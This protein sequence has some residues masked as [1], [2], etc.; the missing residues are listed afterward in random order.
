[1]LT[2]TAEAGKNTFWMNFTNTSRNNLIL[3]LTSGQGCMSVE[4]Y[5]QSTNLFI[6]ANSSTHLHII[7]GRGCWGH[8]LNYNINLASPDNYAEISKYVS[9]LFTDNFK[10][11]GVYTYG[12]S[13]DFSVTAEDYFTKYMHVQYINHANNDAWTT[14]HLDGTTFNMPAVNPYGGASEITFLSFNRGYASIKFNFNGLDYTVKNIYICNADNCTSAQDSK[15]QAI[16][17]SDDEIWLFETLANQEIFVQLSDSFYLILRGTVSSN[18]TVEYHLETFTDKDNFVDCPGC[19]YLDPGQNQ[20]YIINAY[21]QTYDPSTETYTINIYRTSTLNL[22]LLASN[23]SNNIHF[24]SSDF[25]YP[26]QGYPKIPYAF[27]IY[28]DTEPYGAIL[29]NA[30]APQFLPLNANEKYDGFCTKSNTPNS[31]NTLSQYETSNAKPNQMLTNTN[32][33]RMLYIFKISFKRR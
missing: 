28:N 14:A 16:I 31:I 19:A 4:G 18:S 30:N 5:S 25:T 20:I 15:K 10:D 24:S 1:M 8:H 33:P 13:A 26:P 17:K 23:N 7:Q 29:S 3:S 22:K 27:S 12:N 6:F 9:F 32:F 21:F 2:N 11:P